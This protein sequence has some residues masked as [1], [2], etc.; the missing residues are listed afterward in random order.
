MKIKKLFL[1][2]ILFVLTGELFAEADHDVEKIAKQLQNPVAALISVPFQNN[3]EYGLGP[4]EKGSR[5]TLRMQPVIPSSASENWNLIIRP[6]L[7]F[8]SQNKVVNDESQVGLGDLELEMFLSPKAVGSS[9]IIW[10]AGAVFLIPTGID[11]YLSTKKWGI[12]PSAV[13]L[14]QS[15][16]WTFGMLA[17]QVW[18]YAG[19]SDR[20]KVNLTYFQPFMAHVWGKGFALNCSSETS[21]DW[22]G[23]QWTVPLI[24]GVSQILPIAGQLVSLGVSG[25]YYAKSPQYGPQWGIRAV[26]TLLFPTKKK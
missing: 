2:P 7:P 20:S 5:Y 14:K 3:F 25:I 13:I 8:I 24:A 10:G 18:S 19:D 9:G 22:E 1:Y 23:E 15:G 21:Y 16:P 4:N 26:I 11:K 12:G 17:N 6:I